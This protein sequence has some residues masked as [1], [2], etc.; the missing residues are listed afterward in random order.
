MSNF[1]WLIG[2]SSRIILQKL[3]S[4]VKDYILNSN[5]YIHLVLQEIF[6]K[7]FNH[8]SKK[9]IS[10]EYKADMMTCK[11]HISIDNLEESSFDF[12]LLGKFLEVF[13]DELVSTDC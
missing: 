4:N 9:L 5:G 2:N 1:K 8:I 11:N 13:L 3:S 12:H 6:P 10:L 7:L